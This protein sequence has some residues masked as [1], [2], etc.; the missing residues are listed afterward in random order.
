MRTRHFPGAGIQCPELL[1]P[2]GS[3]EALLAAI[4]AGADAVY[5][6]GKK[7]GARHFA[8][9]FTED[10]IR[11]AVGFAHLHGVRV[12]VTVNTLVHDDEL[13]DALE[14]MLSLYGMGVDA[15]LVQDMGLIALSRDMIPGLCL[16]A[17]TQ[18]TISTREGVVWAGNSG[19]SRVVLARETPLSEIDRIMTLT[20]CERP[21]LE[22]FIHGAL[23]YSYSGQCFLS[24]VIGGRSGNRGMCAQPCRKQYRLLR[25]VPDDYGRLTVATEVPFRDRY[26]LSTKDLCCYPRLRELVEWGIAALKIEGRMRPPEYVAAV[27]RAYRVAL[28][29]LQGGS[30]WYSEDD[31]NDMA[32]AFNRGFTAGYLLGERGPALMGRDRPDH[33]G[34]FL[35]SVTRQPEAG[36]ILVRPASKYV[37][38]AGDGVLI[39]DAGG[40]VR[41]GYALNRD[42][43]KRGNALFIPTDI[44]GIKPGSAVFLTR[45]MRLSGRVKEAIH[46]G[47]RRFTIPVGMHVTLTRGAQ[48]EGC[49]SCPGP[50]GGRIAVRVTTG[51]VP[52]AAQTAPA[53]VEAVSRQFRKTGKTPFC[54]ENV[55]I[56]CRGDPFIPLAELNRLRREL[57]S[58]L[59]AA[60]I[61]GFHP[62]SQL[63]EDAAR[64]VRR[65]EEEN[66]CAIERAC[67]EAGKCMT[68]AL[69]AYCSNAGELAAVCRGECDSV[70]YEPSAMDWEEYF[71]SLSEGAG[72]CSERGVSFAWKWPRITGRVFLD[73]ALPRVPCLFEAGVH[74]IMVEEVGMAEAIHS[75]EPRV[76][77]LGGQ[78]LNIFNAHA[79]RLF[80]PRIKFFTLSP[81]LSSAQVAALLAI[82]SRKMPQVRYEIFCQGNLEA[83]IS[84]DS[85]ISTLVGKDHAQ[86]GAVFGLQDETGR[87]FPVSQDRLGRTHVL[88]AVETTLIDRV[89]ALVAMGV[90]SLG[91]DARGRGTRYAAEM[92]R[93]YR[94]CL[95][96]GGS[97][98]TSPGSLARLKDRVRRMARGGITAGHFER[99]VAG[100][101]DR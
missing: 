90:H 15:V 54:V 72:Y 56:D 47:P 6:G 51:F 71:Q 31:M 60:W 22:V 93:T 48:L 100:Y 79:A 23:C 14:Y 70:C 35:G 98:G 17:S 12:Y 53:S 74:R 57:L 73:E 83:V 80:Y 4:A 55:D 36:G 66:S 26:L 61:R 59:Q 43:E 94:E 52:E 76:E 45:S 2:A 88:N 95:I 1:A 16:H 44:H 49:V 97:R 41:R 62:E 75:R 29:A 40:E 21:G 9:N 84:E 77:V 96:A 19:L 64:R 20:S 3:R 37:P 85:L 33:R 10:E 8:A 81:E 11:E 34:L 30:D 50:R 32:T 42:A 68:P 38:L 91:I 67:D 7:F 18:C 92:T 99:G 65:F 82:S 5:L 87:I 27:V 24:S 63:L 13:G 89:P 101:G 69:N 78:G 28:D 58:A 25:G 46:S 39:A 86:G